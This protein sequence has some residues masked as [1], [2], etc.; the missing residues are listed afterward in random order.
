MKKVVG[1]DIGGT[2]IRAAVVD[3]EGKIL[4]REKTKSGAREGIEKL[5]LNLKNII[6]D[7]SEYGAEAVGIG[8]PGIINQKTGHLT[9]APNISGV[10]NFPLF[11][12]LKKN[13]PSINFIVENDANSVALGEYWKGAGSESNSMLMIVIGTGLGGGII[14]N[15][16]LW[17]GEDGMAGEIGHII[18]DPNGPLCNCGN[19]GCFESFVSSEAIRR[20]VK[21]KT[22]LK[23]YLENVHND[24]IPEAVM[25]LAK[26]GEREAKDIWDEIGTSLGI[27]ITS[28]INL[29]NVD[30]VVI[31][32]GV[33]NAW[34][35]FQE[36]M[37]SEMNK[38]ALRGPLEKVSV[39]PAILGDDAG[40]LGSAYLALNSLEI[41]D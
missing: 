41:S 2:N 39:Y 29:L 12:E 25:Q 23:P 32:G 30:S 40:I 33:S 13:L 21:T 31:G 1:I 8:I 7:L 24:D 20:M 3:A 15:G 19:Y 14:L 35:L 16:N 11:N 6:N 38:R 26:K 4:A 18:I 9:Q 27:G 36:N 10:D 22:S 34:E 5:I 37:I 28:L 17:K